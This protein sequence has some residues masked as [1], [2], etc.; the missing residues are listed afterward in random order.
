MR[1]SIC[2]TWIVAVLS[3]CVFTILASLRGFMS[4]DRGT[5]VKTVAHI[6]L[7]RVVKVHRGRCNPAKPSCHLARPKPHHRAAA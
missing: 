2:L 3:I 5:S 6:D 4:E 7:P 1:L